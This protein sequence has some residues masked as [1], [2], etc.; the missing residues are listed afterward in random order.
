[1]TSRDFEYF[2]RRAQQERNCAERSDDSTARRVHQE[3]ADRYTALAREVAPI[4]PAA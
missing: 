1:M 3:M 4:A 2:T